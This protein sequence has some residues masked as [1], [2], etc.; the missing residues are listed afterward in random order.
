MRAKVR[1]V[2]ARQVSGDALKS[3][4]RQV[5]QL[6]SFIRKLCGSNEIEADRQQS[7]HI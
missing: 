4:K 6:G 1:L 2:V 7:E 3:V 5:A